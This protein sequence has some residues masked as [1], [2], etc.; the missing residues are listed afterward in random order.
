MPVTCA[1]KG[2]LPN[3]EVQR[4][5][6]SNRVDCF[7]TTT[8][9]EGLPVSI[10][11]A[12]AYGIPIVATDVGG[13]RE[14][15]DGNGVLLSSDPSAEE[16]GKALI[17]VLLADDN[18]KNAYSEQS[19]KIWERRFNRENNVKQLAT[20]LS[21]DERRRDL[22]FTVNSIKRNACFMKE[23]LTELARNFRVT[24]I[25]TE[26]DDELC[27]SGNMIA[28]LDKSITHCVYHEKSNSFR[29]AGLLIRFLVDPCTR[30]ERREILG[31]KKHIL[32]RLWESCKY[33]RSAE[34]FFE[35]FRNEF[36]EES[37]N[38][39][40]RSVFYSYWLQPHTL[41]MCLHKDGFKLYTRA[42]GYDL[43]NERYTKGLRQPFRKTID[44]QLDGAFF[45]SDAGKA[46][47]VE[48]FS[49]GRPERYHTCYLGSTKT[50]DASIAC[51][52]ERTDD[53]VTLVSCSSLIPLKRVHLIIDALHYV[54]IIKPGVNIRWIHFGDGPLRAELER[55][56]ADRLA[57]TA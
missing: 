22:Y 47:Y 31:G 42:H 38:T 36:L 9:T 33:Y 39:N 51:T 16:T 18:G 28:E 25:E 37:A 23:E 44:S 8:E 19:V 46:Y 15:I 26:A 41:G 14:M 32:R 49:T 6:R 10:M 5:Y 40:N 53:A 54:S 57:V 48:H 2:D 7:I 1:F 56:A 50:G 4:Y 34:L 3:D 24:M 29:A 12:M 17:K 45:V 35:W 27:D 21:D 43:Y 30:E 11:E 52:K 20:L 13:I 55:Y